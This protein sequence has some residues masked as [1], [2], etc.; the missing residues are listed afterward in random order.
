[1]IKKCVGTLY[2]EALKSCLV[3]IYQ[4]NLS[5]HIRAKTNTALWWPYLAYPRS[6]SPSV[7]QCWYCPF[8][9]KE[10]AGKIQIVGRL[11][12]FWYK[13]EIVTTFLKVSHTFYGISFLSVIVGI[14]NFSLHQQPCTKGS[15]KSVYVEKF[16]PLD[17]HTLSLLVL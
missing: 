12:A 2:P 14:L 17:F 6:Q 5:L 1:M 15:H 13:C 9:D 11:E 16:T 8:I 10:C 4:T 7:G 3:W